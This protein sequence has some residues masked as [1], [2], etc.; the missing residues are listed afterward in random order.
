V[1]DWPLVAIRFALYGDL[2]LLFGIPL[3][4]LYGLADKAQRDLLPVAIFCAALS[5]GG[6]LLGLL[7]FAVV[8]ASMSGTTVAGLDPAIVRLLLTQTGMG[9]A[10]LG[11]SAA[12][13][14]ALSIALRGRRHSVG[15][16]ALLA[17]L[18]AIAVSTLAW[19]GHGAASEGAAG[20]IHLSGDIVH[21]LAASA[22]IGAL[23][24][25]VLLVTP[26]RSSS[27]ERIDTAHAALARF[28]VAGSA[29][30][31]LVVATGLINGAFLV[32]AGNVTTLGHSLYGRLL[33]AKLLL[34][35]GMLGCA[36]LN[37]YRLTPRLADAIGRDASAQALAALRRSMAA[38]T[39]LAI[40]VLG[41]VS[42]LGTLQ[43]PAVGS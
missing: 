35:G 30:V 20:L 29:I 31:G 16:L 2:G 36:A 21:L 39:I 33:I 18:G 12:L 7:G 6:L 37:R 25:L 38:E 34:F 14:L 43:P 28:S 40:A 26:R 11:R 10:F 9:W 15:G 22:W 41:L 42:W 32:G 23:A 1:S 4:A 24:V 3:F 19:S 27:I 5:A 13:S 17:S 8:A